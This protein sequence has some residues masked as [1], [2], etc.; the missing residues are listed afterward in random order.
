MDSRASRRRTGLRSG[1]VRWSRRRRAPGLAP[2]AAIRSISLPSNVAT[3]SSVAIHNNPDSSCHRSSGVDWGRPF[4]VLLSN[5]RNER[6]GVTD[7]AGRAAVR[8]IDKARSGASRNK[9]ERAMIYYPLSEPFVSTT[10]SAPTPLLN[11]A[12][13]LTRSHFEILAMAWA[14]WVFDFYDLILYS[15]LLIPLG[16]ELGLSSV[17]VSVVFGASLA[18]TA[19]GRHFLRLSRRPRRPE[20]GSP[21]DDPR[22][23]R[24][25][26]RERARPEPP[27]S[28]ALP[29]R[30]G[31]RRREGSGRPVRRT[32]AKPSPRGSAAG[33]ART[34]RRARRSGS[35]SLPRSGDSS[36]PRSDGG[37]AS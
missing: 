34:S 23:Q 26:S 9:K 6:T 4:D 33:T 19:G 17:Q 11:Q 24:G 8:A 37:R 1:D 16:K 3:P 30:H 29:R 25:H 36:R 15:F 12:E 18:A 7:S 20:A 10:P 14:G 32:S 21:M 5:E 31:T 27:P 13:K 22:V 2:L 35:R 28:P